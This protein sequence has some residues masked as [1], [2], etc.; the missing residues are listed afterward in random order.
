VAFQ[1]FVA[2]LDSEFD[3]VIIDT[4]ASESSA[5]AQ[6]IVNR[7]CGALMVVRKHHTPVRAAKSLSNSLK[8]M[9]ATFMGAVINAV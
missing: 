1:N 4:P 6:A 7:A 8:G 2:Q 5:D 3:V 9:G